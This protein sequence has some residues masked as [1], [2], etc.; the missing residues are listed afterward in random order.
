MPAAVQAATEGGRAWSEGCGQRLRARGLPE[1]LVGPVQAKGAARLPGLAA[2]VL[3]LQN[4]VSWGCLGSHASLTHRL[5]TSCVPG[6]VWGSAVAPPGP[7][8]AFFRRG[9]AHVLLLALGPGSSHPNARR[10]SPVLCQAVLLPQ[11]TRVLQGPCS[12]TLRHVALTREP[13]RVQ[14]PLPSYL[15]CFCRRTPALPTPTL[16]RGP[17]GCMFRGGLEGHI[18]SLH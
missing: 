17:Q 11:E 6:T 1:T 3:S 7:E 2:F 13:S 12:P 9:P 4:R 18:G 15:T 5:S 14:H 16:S 8:N 10:S